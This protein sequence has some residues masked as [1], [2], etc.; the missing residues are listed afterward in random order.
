MEK[1]RCP[2][3]KNIL[4]SIDGLY[5]D[6]DGIRMAKYC[7][8]CYKLFESHA[9]GLVEKKHKTF[10]S[11]RIAE[12]ESEIEGYKASERKKDEQIEVYGNETRRYARLM[13]EV[14][15]ECDLLKKELNKAHEIA[16]GFVGEKLDTHITDKISIIGWKRDELRARLERLVAASKVV[17]KISDRKHNAWDELKTILEEE[18]KNGV[19]HK[20]I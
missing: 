19:D 13:G 12:L 6:K 14:V 1:N 4:H 15:E 11:K 20:T 9:F 5:Y 17:V 3:C 18:E 10:V 2:E 8:K 16:N 7:S